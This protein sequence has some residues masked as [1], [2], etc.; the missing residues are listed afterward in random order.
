MR[1]VW[2]F[3]D[4]LVPLRNTS[5]SVERQSY[6]KHFAVSTIKPWIVIGIKEILNQ[7]KVAYRD[8]DKEQLKQVQ[9]E[10]KKRLKIARVEYK[11][12]IEK[13]LQNRNIC[14][15]CKELNTSSGNNKKATYG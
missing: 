8:R 7:N 6:L 14:D 10:L 11:K 12:E 3:T 13:N 15:V 1:T 5:T 2:T 9:H 4:R